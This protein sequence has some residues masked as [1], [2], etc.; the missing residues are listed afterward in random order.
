MRV[1]SVK[2]VEDRSIDNQL[3]TKRRS[4]HKFNT[5]DSGRRKEFPSGMMRDAEDG[6]P[7]F[8]FIMVPG[9]PFDEQLITRWANLMVRGAKKYGDYNWTNANSEEELERFKASAL[10]HMLQWQCGDEKEDHS[11]GVMYNL[12]AAEMVKWKLKNKDGG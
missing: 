1:V 2:N 4:V 8:R 3:R 11:T 12:M 10:R 6:K 5:L 7:N 9:M